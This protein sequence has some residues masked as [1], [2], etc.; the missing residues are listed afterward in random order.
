MTSSAPPH[1][2]G[3][4]QQKKRR[5]RCCFSVKCHSILTA[6]MTASIRTQRIL[7]QRKIIGCT[8]LTAPLTAIAKSPSDRKGFRPLVRRDRSGGGNSRR[9]SSPSDPDPWAILPTYVSW[10]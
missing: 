3:R 6:F 2:Q 10:G 1:G 7:E 5:R 9:N 4:H 8:H